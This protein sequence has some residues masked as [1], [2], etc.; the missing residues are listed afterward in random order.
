MNHKVQHRV[1][2]ALDQLMTIRRTGL[3][4]LEATCDDLEEKSKG[5]G[6]CWSFTSETLARY[7][8]EFI[9]PLAETIRDA[10]LIFDSEKYGRWAKWWRRWM[11][12][13]PIQFCMICGSWY[14]GKWSDDYCSRECADLD[15]ETL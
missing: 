10:N 14:W 6:E 4:E 12:W 13:S 9:E 8:R 15:M 1:L 7:N 2:L 11:W 3:K 5:S